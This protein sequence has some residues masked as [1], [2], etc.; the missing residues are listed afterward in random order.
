MIIEDKKRKAN[1]TEGLFFF[2]RIVN[3][4]LNRKNIYSRKSSQPVLLQKIL[5]DTTR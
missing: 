5:Q 2:L 3:I 1:P 4:V